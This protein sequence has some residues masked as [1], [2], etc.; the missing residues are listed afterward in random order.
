MCFSAKDWCLHMEKPIDFWLRKGKAVGETKPTERGDRTF[1]G[2]PLGKQSKLQQIFVCF[3]LICANFGGENA[4]KQPKDRYAQ[5]RK[6]KDY[7]W[8][9]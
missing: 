2:D 7:M 9:V 5:S 8:Q 1:E 6:H 4:K 3:F